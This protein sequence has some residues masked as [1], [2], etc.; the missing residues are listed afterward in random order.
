MRPTSF[1]VVNGITLYR[2]I[3]AP[4]LI[5]LVIAGNE[6]LFAWLLA[7]SLF[8]DLVDGT[9]ARQYK[10][11]SRFGSR[12]DSMADDLTMLAGVIGLFVLKSAF[13]QKNSIIIMTLLGLLVVQNGF[14]LWRYGKMSSFHTYAAKLA[15]VLEGI[16]LIFIF[17]LPEP[18]YPLFYLASAVLFLDLVEEIVLVAI[19]KEYRTDVKGLFWVL[20][21]HRQQRAK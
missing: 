21:G 10:V 15:A 14:A 20:R 6:R 16:F 4:V 2:L 18:V 1:Y 12:L 19:L 17:F 5:G 3:A 9:L 8:T 7:V 13:V 11:S